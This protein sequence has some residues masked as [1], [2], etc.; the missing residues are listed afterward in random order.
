[1][2]TPVI[3][4]LSAVAVTASLLSAGAVFAQ[5]TTREFE[6]APRTQTGDIPDAMNEIFF[7][8]SGPHFN[9]RT[10]WRQTNGILGFG[11]LDSAGFRE[12]EII[13]DAN[14]INRAADYLLTQQATSSPVIRVPDLVNPYNTSIQFLP[15][16]QGS[17]RV[18]GS[19][20]IFE[21]LPMQ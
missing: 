7:G 8:N 17:S 4:C 19:E 21:R 15:S 9:N 1:M 13:W 16:A 20:F 2:T 10:L 6:N 18:S 12:R 5:D 11:G 3:R 14:A